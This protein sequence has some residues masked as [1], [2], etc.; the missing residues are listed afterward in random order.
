MSD[1]SAQKVTVFATHGPEDPERAT[2]PFLMANAAL[3]ED[4]E[5]VVILQGPGVL[6]AKE[7]IAGHVFGATLPA[8]S[9][10]IASFLGAGGR[11]LVCTPCLKERK[12][13]A[14]MLIRGAEL[15]NAAHVIKEVTES[16]A[17]LNY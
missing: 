2:L 5:S 3:V 11:L 16:S 4:C 7:G 1:K 9:E 10:Q 14:D 8:L 13:D 12:I 15:T 6:L 17:T